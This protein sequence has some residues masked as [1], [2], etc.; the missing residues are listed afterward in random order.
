MILLIYKEQRLM[1]H[2]LFSDPSD[3]LKL[4]TNRIYPGIN[5]DLIN[6]IN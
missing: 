4:A 2:E 1:Y 3:N 5:L 6:K